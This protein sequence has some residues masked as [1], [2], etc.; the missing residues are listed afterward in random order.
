MRWR[1]ST[2]VILS[3]SSFTAFGAASEPVSGASVGA[4]SVGVAIGWFGL[5]LLSDQL[6]RRTRGTDG[7]R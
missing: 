6:Y 4:L 1:Y 3:C 7:S 2:S 5:R